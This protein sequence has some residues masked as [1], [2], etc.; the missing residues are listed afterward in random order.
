M[1]SFEITANLVDVLQQEIYPARVQIQDGHI[2]QITR[3]HE[4]CEGYIMPGFTDAH[5][6][7][8]SSMLIP[9]EFARL[10]VV[11]GTV[12]TIS[13]PHEIANVL[14]VPGVE[15][16]LE[17]GKQVPF[18]FNFGAPSC[19]PATVFETAG[20][21]I[22]AAAVA[23]LLLRNDIKYLTEMMNF[24]GVLHKDP[25]VMAKIA[26]AKSMNKPVDGH[27]PGLRGE[28]ARNYI[29]AGIS[30]DH[31]CF[32]IEE[33]REKL[34]YGMHILIREGS[35]AKNFEALIPLLPDYYEK[36]MF[37]SDD[38]HPDNLEEG[39]INLLVKR[40]L[41]KGN[42]LF[43]VLRAA[44]VNP[45]LHYQLDNGLLRVDDAADFILVDDLKNFN[46]LGTWINGVKVAENG[47]TLINSV[48]VAPINNF[49]CDPKNVVDF[50]MPCTSESVTVPVIG[51]IEGELITDKLSAVLH[52]VNGNVQSDTKQDVLKLAVV[53]RYTNAPVAMSFIKGFGLK[54]GAIASSVAHDSHNII[55]VGADD[56]SLCTAINAV[57]AAK[58]G[59][60][61]VSKS[62]MD[63]L[64]LP[65]AGLM[66]NLDGYT[67][68]S[69]YSAMDRAAKGIG[70]TL[71]SPYMT[72][73]FMA[74][75]VIP[76][77]KLS[78]KGLFDGDTFTFV[79]QELK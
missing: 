53:N 70:S 67:I 30:T 65:V 14:G 52:P 17:N 22:D 19:V 40:A 29:Q 47:R 38:K 45:V 7:V 25:E 9:S 54:E 3:L 24:P 72:L 39:H 5:V 71:A 59:I 76:H 74:L 56:Q 75:L 31:E 43:K 73:S 42:D 68:S 51:A 46:V 66:S 49:D 6:H 20:A 4:P 1:N 18:K 13:D 11:H 32:T 23:S 44:C 50:F 21:T 64:A 27:A 34:S 33:A 12:A 48:E 8:E 28:D 10:A 63:V 26:A 41:A 60:S 58:G 16:M 57:I 69:K 35:A 62:G 55:A 15:Y 79:D 61:V 2:R 36:I 37:C 77:L 78:D